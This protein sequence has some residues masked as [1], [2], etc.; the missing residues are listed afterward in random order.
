MKK[1]TALFQPKCGRFFERFEAYNRKNRRVNNALC[2]AQI[3]GNDP[4]RFCPELWRNDALVL[5]RGNDF[6]IDRI[7]AHRFTRQ[8]FA[9]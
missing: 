4:G 6:S 5:L 2:D 3:F 8:Q 1:T 9:G 7:N